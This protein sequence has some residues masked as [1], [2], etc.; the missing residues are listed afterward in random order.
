M[1]LT[2]LVVLALVCAVIGGMLFFAGGVAP[3]V[4]RALPVAEGGR[5]LRRLFP[6]YYLVFGV[7]TLVAAAIAAAGGLWR[8]GLLLGLVAVGFAVARQ[9]L[10]PRI[11]GLRDR[12][13][14]GD[15]AAQAPFDTLHRTS[16]WLNGFQLLGL[17]AIAV[18]L[19]SRA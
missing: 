13:T 4:F 7:A 3:Q 5:F 11:N 15:K 6:V 1:P 19:A 14:A 16:V 12:V 8:E 17:V 18:L 9:G 10:M 2:A